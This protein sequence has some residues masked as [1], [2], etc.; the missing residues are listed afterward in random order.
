MASNYCGG[1][2]VKNDENGT[3][4]IYKSVLVRDVDFGEVPPKYMSE[5]DSQLDNIKYMVNGLGMFSCR[6]LGEDQFDKKIYD[7]DDSKLITSMVSG[8][9]ILNINYPYDIIIH[10]RDNN[11][12]MYCL[13][14]EF[15]MKYN[16]IPSKD[17]TFFSTNK[18]PTVI[19]IKRSSG[20]IQK[21][22]I[23]VK[24]G[25][26]IKK[27]KTNND[28]EDQIYFIVS[29]DIDDNIKDIT[30]DS[31]LGHNK[32]VNLRDILELNSHI[33]K[34][35]INFNTLTNSE[36]DNYT[37]ELGE[38]ECPNKLKCDI[39]KRYDT[40]FTLWIENIVEPPISRLGFENI[41]LIH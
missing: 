38:M 11:W 37:C 26:I 5:K 31:Y 40:E 1:V 22:R 35:H 10:H 19:D 32:H 39:L 8:A 6:L 15:Q 24:D 4:R 13:N 7:S 18:Y 21:G 9:S 28:T 41:K 2:V 25:A 14:L 30:D 12:K 3:N 23:D 36:Y 27:S 33:D 20:K 16:I 17:I 29:F 34:I